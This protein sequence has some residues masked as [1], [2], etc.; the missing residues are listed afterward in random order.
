MV[1]ITGTPVEVHYGYDDD[2]LLPWLVEDS[3]GKSCQAFQAVGDLQ[4]TS[5]K[6]AFKH[7]RQR[8]VKGF[9]KSPSQ[10]FPRRFVVVVGVVE[11]V[12]RL[13]METVVHSCILVR[14]RPM[15]SSPDNATLPVSASCMRR[16]ASPA[17]ARTLTEW[18][19]AGIALNALVGGS[20]D[21]RNWPSSPSRTLD[22]QIGT[23]PDKCCH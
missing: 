22:D 21:Q 9:S 18:R 23:R 6:R 17:H 20:D 12:F 3:V 5:G 10:A 13:W 7:P 11:F 19:W 1:P 4:Q 16:R 8:F 2:F 14:K 15:T